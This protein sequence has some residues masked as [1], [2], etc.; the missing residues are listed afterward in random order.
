MLTRPVGHGQDPRTP[1]RSRRFGCFA[2]P[3]LIV[4]IVVGMGLVRLLT[5]TRPETVTR[6]ALDW[7]SIRHGQFLGPAR[8]IPFHP[9]RVRAVLDTHLPLLY[10]VDRL[11]SRATLGA[12][13]VQCLLLVRRPG[14]RLA[15]VFASPIS[16]AWLNDSLMLAF[17]TVFPDAEILLFFIVP[18]RVKWIGILVACV[19]VFELALGD[20]ATRAAILA[21]LSNYALFFA[22]DGWKAVSGRRALARQRSRRAETR[23]T[24]RTL[25]QRECAMCG[26]READG[27]DIR[28][29]T[30]P[31]CGGKSRNLCLQ[32]ARNH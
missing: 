5:S 8:G 31:K 27:A 17:A 28:V 29:C 10:V 3:N 18:V 21:A 23:A 22:E 1:L 2:V 9:S 19:F 7:S 6:L 11:E 25:G 30:C 12:V 32:H 26:V 20:F 15:G 24:V 4:V 16:N 13:P 14:D